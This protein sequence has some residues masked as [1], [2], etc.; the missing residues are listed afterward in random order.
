MSE[1]NFSKAL[2]RRVEA[3]RR[4]LASAVIAATIA[5]ATCAA[6]AQ[7]P[8]GA[9]TQTKAKTSAK[10]KT[11]TASP[12]NPESVVATVGSRSI[13]R[14]EF[15]SRYATRSQ[16]YRTHPGSD[17]AAQPVPIPGPPPR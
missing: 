10:P 12:A 7:T 8:A 16:Q 3:A 4:L 9:T 11:P 13:G 14:A 5:L 17:P 6:I 2:A 15:E 1:H